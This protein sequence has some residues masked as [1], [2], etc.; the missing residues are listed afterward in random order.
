[1]HIRTAFAC[2]KCQRISY[3]S[4]SDDPLDALWRKQAKIEKKLGPDWQRPKGMRSAT[5]DLVRQQIWDIEMRRDDALA[6]YLE[7]F[8]A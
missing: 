4:Q 5:Y 8:L 2:R 1:M 6:N 3:A 7:R